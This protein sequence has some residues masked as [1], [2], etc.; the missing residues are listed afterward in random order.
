MG[1]VL[2]C[3]DQDLTVEERGD[4][5]GWTGGR[6]GSGFGHGGGHVPKAQQALEAGTALIFQPARTWGPRPRTY[7]KQRSK[8]ADTNPNTSK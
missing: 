4:G 6:S 7:R 1:V 2:A 5:Q 3:L 8:T